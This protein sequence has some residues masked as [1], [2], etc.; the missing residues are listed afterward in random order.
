MCKGDGV[1]GWSKR[2]VG[3]YIARLVGLWKLKLHK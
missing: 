3:G 1:Y 2:R